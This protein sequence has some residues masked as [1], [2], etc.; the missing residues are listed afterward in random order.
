MTVQDNA[1]IEVQNLTNHQV[2]YISYDGKRQAFEGQQIK[3]I[4]AEE[5]RQLGYSK[6][7]LRLIREF[8]SIKNQEL[9]REFNISDDSFEHEYQWTRADVDNVLLHGSMDA[10][11]DALDFAPDGIIDLIVDRAVYLRI[12]DVNKRKVIAESTGR[13]INNMITVLEN[14][15]ASVEDDSAASQDAPKKTRRLEQNQ[16]SEEQGRRVQS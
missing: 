7:G 2:V 4:R 9:A 13:D 15:E 16:K 1:L 6:G 10:L 8:L 12:A 5:L 14:T 11:R 3:K